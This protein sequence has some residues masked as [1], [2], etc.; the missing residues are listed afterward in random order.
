MDGPAPLGAAAANALVSGGWLM[1]D[2][3]DAGFGGAPAPPAGPRQHIPDRP[4]PHDAPTGP[5]A[6][7][8][9]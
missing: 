3:L 6:V 2:L 7:H 4:G 5:S 8:T 9:R 1:V